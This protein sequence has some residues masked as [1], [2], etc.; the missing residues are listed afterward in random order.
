MRSAFGTHEP[1]EQAYCAIQVGNDQ[2]GYF[3]F[4]AGL[5]GVLNEFFCCMI[6]C[7]VQERGACCL[8]ETD[9]KSVWQWEDRSNPFQP[10]LN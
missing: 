3:N 10:R 4:K 8:T 7:S 2:I 9:S 1:F 5:K 6:D